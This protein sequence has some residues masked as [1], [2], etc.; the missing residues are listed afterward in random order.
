MWTTW[1]A[2][3][4]ASWA[5]PM[6][7]SS[8]AES[9]KSSSAESPLCDVPSS[10]FAYF[11]FLCLPFFLSSLLRPHPFSPEWRH[12]PGAC[13]G[14]LP[15][16]EE[17]PLP[18]KKEW[19]CALSAHSSSSSLNCSFVNLDV[20][21]TSLTSDYPLSSSWFTTSD[22]ILVYAVPEMQKS[23]TPLDSPRNLKSQSSWSRSSPRSNFA[24]DPQPA[25]RRRCSSCF[26]ICEGT[27]CWFFFF[28]PPTSLPSLKH[29]SQ[30]NSGL[31]WYDFQLHC[32][33]F[34]WNCQQKH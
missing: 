6:G 26:K 15:F 20:S 3:R 34:G 9:W 32:L 8:T 5:C 30:L 28:P 24:L 23:V 14:H 33:F 4:R 1:W 12:I 21:S 10:P 18:V 17:S 11:W 29:L 25:D 27:C 2:T 31:P 22:L 16:P 13:A 7:G 19:Y